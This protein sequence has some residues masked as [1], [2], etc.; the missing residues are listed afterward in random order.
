[1]YYYDSKGKA[2]SMDKFVNGYYQKKA[3]KQEKYYNDTRKPT[4]KEG[5]INKIDPKTSEGQGMIAGICIVVLLLA[6]GVWK[7]K[8][9]NWYKN[10]KSNTALAKFGC[11]CRPTEP[12]ISNFNFY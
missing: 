12:S 11:G 8:G 10:R 5:F 3:Q 1:M 2:V 9:E 7:W 6:F 4:A